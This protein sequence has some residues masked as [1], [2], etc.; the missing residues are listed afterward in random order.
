M[1]NTKLWERM[2][3]AVSKV[4]TWPDWKKGSTA[5]TRT[6]QQSTST[7]QAKSDLPKQ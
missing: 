4:Q 2:D 6:E 3:Q 5:N 1:K 7:I